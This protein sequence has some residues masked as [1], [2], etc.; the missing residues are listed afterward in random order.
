MKEQGA[1]S[2]KF[3]IQNR[4]FLA[5][6]LVLLFAAS[7]IFGA[8][9]LQRLNDGTWGGK[10]IQFEV[11]EGSVNIEYDCAHGAI[12]G[13]L[14][15][16]R[17]GSFSWHGTYTREHG[18]P[19]RLGEKVNNQA[20]IYSGSIKVDTMTLTVKLENSNDEPLTFTLT[21]DTIGRVWKCK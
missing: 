10:H 7:I 3:G 13:P 21:R 18:G 15:V 14:T 20:A 19:I 2:M 5:G 6:A 17:E 11:S 1:G 8:R 16:D 9:K 12:S 4:L